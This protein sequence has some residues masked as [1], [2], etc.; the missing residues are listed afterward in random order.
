VIRVLVCD[1]QA[2][3][4]GGLRMILEAQPDIEV[5][6]EAGD[7][8]EAVALSRELAPDVVLMDIRM[9]ALDGIEATRQITARGDRSPRVLV[10]TTYG[11]D[12]YVYEALKAGAG[13]FFVK[14]D[15]PERL[16]EGVRAVASGEALLGP[17]TTRLLVDRFLSGP[18]PNA[19]A[20]PELAELTP[21]E[22]EVLE[23]L[24][25]GLSNSEMAQQLF[26]GEGTVKTHV[27]R[28]LSKLGLRD[29]VQ[30]VVFAYESGLVRRGEDDA[31]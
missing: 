7:G 23:L 19:P 13:G 1:D 17:E 30:A 18:P 9:P 29:R 4:R 25:R 5:A 14:T 16:V 21:R 22:R 20:P 15:S 28:L 3:V 24:A 12:E 8:R 11:L 31:E 6:G 26:V 27:A 2:V 10:L